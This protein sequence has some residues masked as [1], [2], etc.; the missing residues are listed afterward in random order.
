[1]AYVF[2]PRHYD[3]QSEMY[4]QL[5]AMTAAG[6]GV[7]E[8]CEF[9]QRSPPHPSYA[10]IF[11][12]LIA[13]LRRG[14]NFTEACRAQK[15]WLPEFDIT[16]IE[17]SEMSGRMD[18]CFRM[19]SDFYSERARLVRH[20]LSELAWPLFTL[21]FAILVF[22]T[23]QLV[24]LIIQGGSFA[25]FILQKLAV[26]GPLYAVVVAFIVAGQSRHGERWRGLQERILHGIPILGS[27][28]RTLALARLCAALEAL[29]SAGM[30]ILESWLIAANT[31]GSAALK[32]AVVSWTPELRAGAT[33][34]E[35]LLRSRVFPTLFASLYQTG[36]TSGKLDDTLRRLYAMFTEEASRKLRA[37]AQ[38]LPRLLML[39]IMVG[40]ALQVFSFWMGY[41]NT[42]GNATGP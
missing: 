15:G 28:R 21:H 3:R 2:S 23:G 37:F 27:A 5:A 16:L 42:V 11:Q 8:S 18:A 29:L 1:M 13:D 33:P 4:H 24:R 22:P 30:P 41:F 9:L 12:S 25:E 35:M 20:V 38:W 19:L 36:E 14:L 17:A 10:P 34:G 40:V 32:S 39:G 31:C 6:V 26:A 7:I